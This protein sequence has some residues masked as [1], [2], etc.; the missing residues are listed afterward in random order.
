MYYQFFYQIIYIISILYWPVWNFYLMA[1]S[2]YHG[3]LTRILLLYS[4][5]PSLYWISQ[6]FLLSHSH[7]SSL[8][9]WNFVFSTTSHSCFLT[10]LYFVDLIILTYWTRI[11]SSIPLSVYRPRFYELCLLQIKD[12]WN[13]ISNNPQDFI[14]YL[15]FWWIQISLLTLA[16]VWLQKTNISFLSLEKGH[17]F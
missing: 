8:F 15:R 12:L 9:Y 17:I 11:R 10:L 4:Q 3:N 13:L 14:F 7:S 2:P 6:S 16:F 5:L 1:Y